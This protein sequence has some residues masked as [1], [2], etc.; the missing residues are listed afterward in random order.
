LGRDGKVGDSNV[1][2]PW[3]ARFESIMREALTV[4]APTEDL[5]PDLNTAAAGLDSLASVALL[6]ELE[7]AYSIEIPDSLL[8]ME[9]FATPAALW[10]MLES[11]RGQLGSHCDEGTGG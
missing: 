5:R 7:T 11:A 9:N 4:L 2:P 3:D 6:V 8:T 1:V 10:K